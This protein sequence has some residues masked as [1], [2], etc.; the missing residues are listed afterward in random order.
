MQTRLQ[1]IDALG[2]LVMALMFGR[3]ARRPRRSAPLARLRLARIPGHF[4]KAWFLP[5][6]GMCYRSGAVLPDLAIGDRVRILPNH[7]CAT[8][9]Q[10]RAYQVVRGRSDRVEAEWPRF[11]GWQ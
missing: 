10:H 7:A 6:V 4:G 2:G 5:L 11:G 1:N 8:G 3:G 9:A